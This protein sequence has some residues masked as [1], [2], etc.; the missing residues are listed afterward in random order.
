MP[1]VLGRVLGQIRFGWLWLAQQ[2][3]WLAA[4]HPRVRSGAFACCRLAE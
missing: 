4:G 3:F 2:D 1:T